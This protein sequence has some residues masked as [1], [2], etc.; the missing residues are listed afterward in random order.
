MLL[1]LL[2]TLACSPKDKEVGARFLLGG[3][4]VPK[5][6][7]AKTEPFAETLRA[8]VITTQEEQR[9]FLDSL[10][11]VRLRGNIESLDRA[12]LDRVV[13]LAAYYLWRPLKGDPL[14]INGLRTRGDRVEVDLEL[15][16]DPQGRERPFLMAPLQIAAVERDELPR[17]VPLEFVFLVNGEVAA[18]RPATLE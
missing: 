5:G 7:D 18:I 16:E 10:E 8:F 14:F 3:W 6:E 1:A 9:D 13:I 12:D 2:V 11:I 17:G 15:L 4:V